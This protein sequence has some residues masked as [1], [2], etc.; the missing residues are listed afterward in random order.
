M[1]GM[2]RSLQ[3]AETKRKP[4]R[5]AETKSRHEVSLPVGTRYGHE[6]SLQA[7]FQ[8]TPNRPLQ[9][10][11]RRKTPSAVAAAF[12]LVFLL[13]S[14]L[15]LGVVVSQSGAQVKA[16]QLLGASA[17]LPLASKTPQE[18]PAPML[19]LPTS[20]PEISPTAPVLENINSSQPPTAPKKTKQ[21]NGHK[22]KHKSK[23]DNGNTTGPTPKCGSVPPAVEMIC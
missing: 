11:A 15:S 21:G 10:V 7:G 4:F 5:P 17:Q 9:S 16:T 23:S 12:L 20:T 8:A 6:V 19:G 3:P 1:V 14:S 13:M 22:H 18:N 2:I